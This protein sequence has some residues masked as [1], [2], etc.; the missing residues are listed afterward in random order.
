MTSTLIINGSPSSS[1]RTLRLAQALGAR[2]GEHG[3]DS[4]L[5]DLRALPA[6]ALLHAHVDAPAIVQSLQ[7]LANARGVVIVTPVYKAAYSGMLKAFLD[8]LPQF[9]LR[10]KVVLPLAMGGTLAHVLSIVYALRPVLHSLDPLHIV[11][12]LFLLDKQVLV[13][14]DGGFTL[15]ADLSNKLDAVT[16]A[17]VHA[18]HRAAHP[19]PARARSS[20]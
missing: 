5:L 2:L 4:S 20:S 16:Q 9:G 18:L 17:Y 14:D 6:E 8:L 13:Q 12:G 19:A 11:T 15:D 1:S 10:D 3:I 7:Q